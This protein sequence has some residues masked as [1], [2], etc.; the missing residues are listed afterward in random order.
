[1][2]PLHPLRVLTPADRRESRRVNLSQLSCS[3]REPSA[4]LDDY[5]GDAGDAARVFTNGF[6]LVLSEMRLVSL[7]SQ[8]PA[9]AVWRALQASHPPLHRS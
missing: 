8:H 5:H 3:R 6:T 9:D 1:M 2:E 4:E 7:P